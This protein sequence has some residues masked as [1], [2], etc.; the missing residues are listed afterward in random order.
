MEVFLGPDKIILVEQMNKLD[1][2]RKE[3]SMQ[4]TAS[5]TWH[6]AHGFSLFFKSKIH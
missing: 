6:H 3:F 1:Q 2:N 5:I 4:R